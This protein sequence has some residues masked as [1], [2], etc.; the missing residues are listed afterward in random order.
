MSFGPTQQDEVRFSEEALLQLLHDVTNPDP[1]VQKANVHRLN[2]LTQW[3]DVLTT[4]VRVLL[5]DGHTLSVRL[6]AA[7]VSRQLLRLNPRL[8]ETLPLA[9]VGP[10]LIQS[11]VAPVTP[12]VEEA[13]QTA[14]ANVLA[15]VLRQ[16]V[17]NRRKAGL[18]ESMAVATILASWPTLLP[19]LVELARGLRTACTTPTTTTTGQLS[20]VTATDADASVRWLWSSL[21]GLACVV[22]ILCEDCP[23]LLRE[24]VAQRVETGADLCELLHHLV[25]SL[26]ALL[27]VYGKAAVA[28]AGG[29]ASA[30]F[31]AVCVGSVVPARL[32]RGSVSAVFDSLRNCLE[33][34]ILPIESP[35]RG[36]EC[37]QRNGVGGGGEGGAP[38]GP[39]QQALQETVK[40]V[41]ELHGTVCGVI[42]EVILP[43]VVEV[44]RQQ[45]EPQQ[46]QPQSSESAADVMVSFL[47]PVMGYTSSTVL[48]ESFAEVSDALLRNLLPVVTELWRVSVGEENSGA[49]D[50][51]LK[52]EPVLLA[53][54]Q[55]LAEVAHGTVFPS[56]QDALPSLLGALYEVAHLPF[57]T[58][59]RQVSAQMECTVGQPDKESDVRGVIRSGGRGSSGKVRQPEGQQTARIPRITDAEEEEEEEEEIDGANEYSGMSK[60]KKKGKSANDDDFDDDDAVIGEGVESLLADSGARRQ[61]IVWLMQCLAFGDYHA[62][63]VT[64][65]LPPCVDV[66]V[67]SAAGAATAQA[68]Q[69]AHKE[70]ALFMLT[71][72][73]EEL[74]CEADGSSVDEASEAQGA[75]IWSSAQ[76]ISSTVAGPLNAFVAER[77]AAGSPSFDAHPPPD[78]LCF[79]SFPFYLRLQCVRFLSAVFTGCIEAL[80][81]LDPAHRVG[82]KPLSLLAALGGPQNLLHALVQLARWE[83]NKLV[84]IACMEAIEA[85]MLDCCEP[86]TV[87]PSHDVADGSEIETDSDELLTSGAASVDGVQNNS[88]LLHCLG[89]LPAAGEAPFSH[90]LV[91][92]INHA[93]HFQLAPRVTLY[94]VVARVMP[95]LSCY[96]SVGV[97]NEQTALQLLEG[98]ARQYTQLTVFTD[99]GATSLEAAS[100]LNCLCDVTGSS[101]RYVA[102]ALNWLVQV[103][104]HVLQGYAHRA[105]ASSAAATSTTSQGV[106]SAE[107]VCMLALDLVSCA[108]DAMLDR[109]ALAATSHTDERAVAQ[110][111][112]LQEALAPHTDADGK[113]TSLLHLSGTVLEHFQQQQQLTQRALVPAAQLPGNDEASDDDDAESCTGGS[114]G[115]WADIRRACLALLYDGVLLFPGETAFQ[116]EVCRLALTELTLGSSSSSSVAFSSW[117]QSAG[118]A[119][120]FLCLGEIFTLWAQ[121]ARSGGDNEAVLHVVQ[122]RSGAA[123]HLFDSILACLSNASVALPSNLRMNMTSALA[124]CAA[125]LVTTVTSTGTAVVPLTAEEAIGFSGVTVKQLPSF[126]PSSDSNKGIFELDQLLW[127]V[128]VTVSSILAQGGGGGGGSSGGVT[129]SQVRLP[130]PPSPLTRLVEKATVLVVRCGKHFSQAPQEPP[131]WMVWRPLAVVLLHSK[132]SLSPQ[133]KR[134]VQ[135]FAQIV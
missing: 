58:F 71:D 94:S 22:G 33:R 51:Y 101:G 21:Y 85:I 120:A 76:S 118:L 95:L 112:R 10:A 111:R 80:T 29:S 102:P 32:A 67:H 25:E 49:G 74:L 73:I 92:L 131:M 109:D 23:W 99:D 55:F 34:Y 37:E 42:A 97:V 54:L 117:A 124:A 44:L 81:R 98:L 113:G 79:T 114:G 12:P 88:T 17:L 106:L 127:G 78:S 87:V 75:L 72:V 39:A 16:L 93:P 134:H 115:P 130:P 119:N 105:Y 135:Q 100:L 4:T 133:Q 96:A 53:S 14:T 3:S 7:S 52:K 11:I 128:G 46:Q 47:T 45:G 77:L 48:V 8:V 122:Q 89:L 9:A 38:I 103:C 40:L 126:A 121:Q 31:G 57:S 2:E 123:K 132:N 110:L 50:R 62:T 19:S 82:S 56:F 64:S 68:Q 6:S 69:T 5:Q 90:L 24:M 84:Q 108:C 129:P 26:A 125:L 35:F 107:D 60:R 28:E 91:S 63:L 66:V 43:C 1:A 61:A 116:N 30:P 83:V 27:Q 86:V 18:T 70:A 15:F 41:Q 13:L 59:L 104:Q 36:G 65:L 20:N